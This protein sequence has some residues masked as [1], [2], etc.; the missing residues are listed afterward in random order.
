MRLMRFGAVCVGWAA[1]AAVVAGCQHDSSID[2]TITV[3][4]FQRETV[5][6]L[7]CDPPGGDLP[8]AAAVCKAVAQHRDL[9]LNPPPRRSSCRGGPGVPP[10]IS[11]KGR[12]ADDAVEVAGRSC[13]WPGG[14]GLAVVEAAAGYPR[15]FDQAVARLA[16]AKTHACSSRRRPGPKC[17]PA[18]A[19]QKR[20][21]GREQLVAWASVP[22]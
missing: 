14:L 7:R 13:D 11:I 8:R 20:G 12:Y 5:Y 1:L 4:A 19:I 15:P 2:L 9:F 6:Q 17:E 10:S 21:D 3:T 22:E 16:A 18:C